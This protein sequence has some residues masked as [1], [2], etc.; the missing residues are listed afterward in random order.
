MNV[1]IHEKILFSKTF[2][3]VRSESNFDR[4]CEMAM[5]MAI[6]YCGI[7]E[8]GHCDIEGYERSCCGVQVYFINLRMYGWVE[9]CYEF[10]CAL[11]KNLDG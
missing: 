6:Q 1:G 2:S 5:K 3:V 9:C 4:A 7:D 11:V 10:E 8:D